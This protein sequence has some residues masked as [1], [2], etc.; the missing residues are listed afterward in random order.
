[1]LF[2]LNVPLETINLEVMLSVSCN[3]QLPV[4]LQVM[5]Y[6]VLPAVVMVSLDEEPKVIVPVPVVQV[7]PE[8]I[9]KLPNTP[10]AESGAKVPLNPVKFK[11]RNSSPDGI[12]NVSVP[13]VTLISRRAVVIF[14]LISTVLVPVPPEYVRFTVGVPV[15]ENP[16]DVPCAHIVPALPDT[17]IAAPLPNVIDLVVEPELATEVTF[18]EYVLKSNVPA[19]KVNPT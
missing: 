11:F 2:V 9:V 8:E 10:N 18:T 1:M 13:A 15:E 4:P 3:V 5:A 12:A 6:N 19:V 16:V 7:I 17:F 14:P